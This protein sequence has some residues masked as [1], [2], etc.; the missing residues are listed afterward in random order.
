MSCGDPIAK[1]KN[2]DTIRFHYL[3]ET[4]FFQIQQ[5]F[6]NIYLSRDTSGNINPYCIGSQIFQYESSDSLF[7]EIDFGVG[8]NCQD[9]RLRQGKLISSSPLGADP[10]DVILQ[11]SADHYA[12]T[13]L[14]GNLYQVDF[15]YQLSLMDAPD[16]LSIS[17]KVSKAVFSNL[18]GTFFWKGNLL[19][20]P[21]QLHDDPELSYPAWK[22][23]GTASLKDE[24]G[25]ESH[26]NTIS[27]LAYTNGCSHAVSG[28]VSMSSAD[29]QGR[30]IDFGQGE[31]DHQATVQIGVFSA[32]INLP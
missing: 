30:I 21:F 11:L 3:A 14:D 12:F 8:C 7:T 19:T 6:T 25:N 16:K 4:E 24:A 26:A 31:C 5:M 22:V 2:L 13:Y 17:S 18:N 9:G 23:S 28:I 15:I 1:E 20:K 29:Q 27:P 10:D 32:S